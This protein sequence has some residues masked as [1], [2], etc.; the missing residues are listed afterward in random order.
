[1]SAV[2]FVLERQCGRLGVTLKRS[3]MILLLYVF[4]FNL[5][6]GYIV[7]NNV[8]QEHNQQIKFEE[9]RVTLRSLMHFSETLEN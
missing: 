3:V 5:V 6:R 8:V 7:F 1:M 2:S 9:I 4:R